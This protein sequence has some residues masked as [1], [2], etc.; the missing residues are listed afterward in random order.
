MNNFICNV[1]DVG[2]TEKISDT[3]TPISS[4]EHFSTGLSDDEEH[5]VNN[6]NFQLK[7]T[8]EHSGE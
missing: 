1:G 7:D 2:A 5:N 3:S 4:T 6:E 8:I